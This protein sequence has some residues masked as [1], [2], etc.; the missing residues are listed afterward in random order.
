MEQPDPADIFAQ[1][2]EFAEARFNDLH[3]KVE[4]AASGVALTGLSIFTVGSYGRLEA[5]S[6]SDID[7]FF[8]YDKESSK[9]TRRTSELKLFGRLIEIVEE[10]E[11]PAL[12]N[13]AA[14]LESHFIED[15]LENLG[16][17]SDDARNYFTMRMLLL[18]ESRCVYG[19][20]SYAR[21]IAEIVDSYYRDYPNHEGFFRPWF[22][23]NDIM[24]FWKTLLLNY[25]HKRNRPTENPN[26]PKPRVR[27]FKLKFSRA[28]TCFATI[29]AI[30]SSPTP[31]TRENIRELV[32]ITPRERL[33]RVAENIPEARDLVDR[34]LQ[35]YAWF[36]EQTALATEDLDQLFVNGDSKREMFKRADSYAAKLFDLLKMIDAETNGQ[37]LRALVV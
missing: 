1:R 37:L 7:L 18:L 21:V 27:N 29:C 3:S 23:L 32:S 16:S 9:E 8:I 28:T 26:D 11:F 35:D 30:G 4:K 33:A 31:V 20:G 12:S 17:P 5:S 25:E 2:E 36:L 22:L 15:V 14:Y 34:I 10:M 6:H 13:D 24:R 19:D